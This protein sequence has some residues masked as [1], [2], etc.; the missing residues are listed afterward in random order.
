MGPRTATP[1]RS[2]GW[3]ASARAR[4]RSICPHASWLDQAEIY[5]SVILREVLTPNDFTSLDQIRDR[6]A[7]FETRHN[8]IARPFT[9]KF[10]R[11]QP[12]T[13][14]STQTNL[15]CRE[16]KRWRP[17]LRYVEKWSLR[18]E[19]SVEFAVSQPLVGRSCVVEA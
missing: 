8:A 5:F 6:L 4:S 12:I 1:L 15:S 19:S 10:T 7:A 13:P 9:W 17:D 11:R 3:P 14:A 16:R 18:S 2:N